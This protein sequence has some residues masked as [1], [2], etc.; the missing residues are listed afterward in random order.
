MNSIPAKGGLYEDL[1]VTW[2]AMPPKR[3]GSNAGKTSAKKLQAVEKEG[4]V[5]RPKANKNFRELNSGKAP[6]KG[7]KATAGQPRNGKRA[8]D[9]VSLD[10]HSSDDD[11][12]RDTSRESPQVSG[13]GNTSNSA[14]PED[15]GQN[16]ESSSDVESSDSDKNITPSDANT[17][18]KDLPKD[19]VRAVQNYMKK[20][21][22]SKGKK[23]GKKNR[24]R[25]RKDYSS[26]DDSS[27]DTVSSSSSDSS[28][29][30]GDISS[31]ES[32]DEGKK[33]G[34]KRKREKRK[35]KRSK[36]QKGK[37]SQSQRQVVEP[38]VNTESPSQSTL[39]TRGCKSPEMPSKRNSSGTDSGGSR[40]IDQGEDTDEFLDSLEAS[41]NRAS[42]VTD[43]RRERL[44]S[45]VRAGSSNGGRDDR[46][47]HNRSNKEAREGEK[48]REARASAKADEMVRDIQRNKANLAK[49]SGELRQQLKSLL[50][51]FNRLHLT[52]HIDKKLKNAILS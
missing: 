37:S 33:K 29:G 20:K 3:K 10:L 16:P 24:K 32:S 15:G 7:A 42:P 12:D 39:Y 6:A 13:G 46:G 48:E 23:R 26:N 40:L 25:S 19:L 1:T 8:D 11:L 14:T 22:H 36:R 41:F 18:Q 31:D 5:L 51:D 21:R 28:S 2:A 52:S 27:S 34:R 44:R 9:D 17:K 50:I 35:K 30:T 49:P 45:P 43:R 47:D 38:A 4:R